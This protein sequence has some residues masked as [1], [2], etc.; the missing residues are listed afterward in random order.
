MDLSDIDFTIIIFNTLKQI[1]NSHEI[2]TKE[3]ELEKQSK[4]R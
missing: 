4:F 2:Y 3:D 1:K